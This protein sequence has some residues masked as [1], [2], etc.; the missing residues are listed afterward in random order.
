MI[1]LLI[2]L[3]TVIESFVWIR[4]VVKITTVLL[5]KTCFPLTALCWA[6]T[7]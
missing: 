5:F 6:E 2:C 7:L 3:K 1:D 4:A